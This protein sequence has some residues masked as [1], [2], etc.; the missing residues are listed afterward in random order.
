V[1]LD[2]ARALAADLDAHDEIAFTRERFD[3]PEGTLYFDGNSLGPL[4]HASRAAISRTSGSSARGTR[5]GS[6]C[7]PAWGT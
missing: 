2:E 5:T 3:I 4:T 6:R 1:R 7:P